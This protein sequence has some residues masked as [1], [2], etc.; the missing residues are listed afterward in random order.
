[1]AEYHKHLTQKLQEEVT[2]FLATPNAEELADIQEVLLAL[3]R[4]LHISP[5]RLE[6]VQVTKRQQRGGFSKKII[7]EAVVAEKK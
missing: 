6:R 5:R 3:R 7:L 1:M 4:H 2:E